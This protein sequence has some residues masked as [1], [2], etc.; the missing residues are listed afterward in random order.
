M[1]IAVITD[2]DLRGSGYKNLSF[3]LLDGLT[4]LGHEIIVTGLGYRGEE[5][6]HK[7]S[8]IPARDFNEI[9]AMLQNLVNEW[10][11][12]VLL[13][14]LDVPL[15][16]R[17][18]QQLQNRPFKYVGVMPIEADPLCMTW[19]MVLMQMDK[20]FIISEFG[21]HE[22]EKMGVINAE[23]LRVGIDTE[24]WR[25]PEEGER[26]KLRKAL[27]YDEDDFIILTIADNQERKNLSKGFEIISKVYEE[28]KNVKHILGTREHNL[29]GWKLRDLAQHFG[30]NQIVSIYERG[31]SFK[32]LWSLYAISDCFFL[33]SKAEGLGIPLLEAMAVGVPCVTTKC[34]AMTELIGVD[35][36]YL[37]DYDY[38]YVDCFGNGNRYFASHEH[39]TEIIKRM[40]TSGKPDHI[41]T[42]AREYVENRKW[43]EP[44]DQLHEALESLLE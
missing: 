1:K 23:H 19:A 10:K 35:R 38:V 36:G 2:A 44:I 14:L 5:H 3:P 12:D 16:E 15:Q 4:E 9:F 29:V 34:T 43:K 42:N 31:I 21:T 22:A 33:P 30:I 25:M 27:G 18:L 6:H 32:E 24:A 13:T 8:V 41:I 17:I 40:I 26:E 20:A 28:H 7:F 11:F 37:I 39:G